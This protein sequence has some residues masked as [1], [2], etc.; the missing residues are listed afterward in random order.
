[1]PQPASSEEQNFTQEHLNS[2]EFQESELSVQYDKAETN[3]HKANEFHDRAEHGQAERDRIDAERAE[4]TDT[5]PYPEHAKAHRI[6]AAENSY[7]RAINTAEDTMPSREELTKFAKTIESGVIIDGTLY[8][9]VED[10]VVIDGKVYKK[11]VLGDHI[12]GKNLSNRIKGCKQRK[13]PSP[14]SW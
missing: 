4:G 7:E 5:G 9:A 8:E 11:V 13:W 2:Q 10:E 12:P 1:M 14:S 6:K 3:A